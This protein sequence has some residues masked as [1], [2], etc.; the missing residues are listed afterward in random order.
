MKMRFIGPQK[1]ILQGGGF[2]G[3]V[4]PG[5]EIEVTDSAAAE[6]RD[7]DHWE[8]IEPES[9][10]KTEKIKKDKMEGVE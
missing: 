9:K 6:M 7:H 4:S 1:I 5:D 8:L 10:N 2:H 3:F